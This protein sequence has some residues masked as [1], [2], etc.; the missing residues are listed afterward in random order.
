MKKS[1]N[2]KDYK[3]F[4]ELRDQCD[5]IGFD[6][7]NRNIGRLNMTTFL[8]GFDKKTQDKMFAR[9]DKESENS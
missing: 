6:N 9:D 7:Y 3:K 2:E 5:L 4:V 8:K 1:Y